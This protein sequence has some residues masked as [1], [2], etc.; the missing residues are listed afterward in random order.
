MSSPR[1]IQSAL[2]AHRRLLSLLDRGGEVRRSAG[3]FVVDNLFRG[4]ST[5]G[6]IHPA[7]RPERHG[8]EIVQDVANRSTG[9]SE[10]LLDV[11]RPLRGEPPYPV[12]LY[13][14]GGGFRILSKDS[15][16]VMGLAF[17]RRG[18]LV[19]NM[20]YR[21][22]P[23]HPYPAAVEDC[24][25]A[26]GWVAQ[27]AASFGGD[28]DRLVLAGE[29][30]GANLVTA[31]A[32]TMSY[33]REEPWARRAFATGLTARAVIPACGIFQV[34]DVGRLARRKPR[35]SSFIADRLH[36][37]ELSYLAGVQHA[38]GSRELDLADVA[39]ALERGEAPDRPLPPF[40]LPVGTRDP[41]LPDTRRLQAALRA[42][43]ATADAAYY[44]GELHAFHAV[45]MRSQ[46]RRCWADI[47]AF[48]DRQGVAQ[49]PL[50]R[51][52]VGEPQRD[53]QRV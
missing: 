44:P 16:W 48:L 23:Q 25:D 41:L 28:L 10:H 19:F 8:V 53:R 27:N 20:S 14:H 11:Y 36:E 26:L 24:C 30:A 17:A 50:D 51:H 42:L 9:L 21:L 43:G 5:V 47:F 39:V 6:K 22:A 13:V 34:S 29:S 37:V 45:V 52:G 18:Y 12:V 38:P 7:A 35:M 46:A 33:Q 1:R 4:L 3:A 15:H 31:L 49:A 40:F 2:P 32:L